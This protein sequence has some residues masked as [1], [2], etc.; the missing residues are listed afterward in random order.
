MSRSGLISTQTLG[1]PAAA[2]NPKHTT[3]GFDAKFNLILFDKDRLH[4]RY[5]A[6]YVAAFWRIVTFS[7]L[8]FKASI[9]CGKFALVLGESQLLLL[10]A[11][12]GIKL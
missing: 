12:S 6:K 3:H 2:D 9:F 5:F 4:F 7:Q 10:F 8:A 11:T 1:I